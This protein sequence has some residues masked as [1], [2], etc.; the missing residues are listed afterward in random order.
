M[1]KVFGINT[2]IRGKVG[3]YIYCQTKVGTLQ[4]TERN[5][6]MHRHTK[7]TKAEASD[8]L[9]FRFVWLLRRLSYSTRR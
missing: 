1:A 5:V 9:G 3:E 8:G 2:K 6:I 7:T 4:E